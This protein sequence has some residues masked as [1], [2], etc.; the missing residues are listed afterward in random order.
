M[1]GVVL[2][3]GQS[4]RMGRDKALVDVDGVAM[5][6]RVAE[7]QR[8]AGCADVVL[9]G[10]S[11]RAVDGLGLEVLRE[12][13]PGLGPLSGIDAG[14]NAA[15][16]RGHDLMMCCPCDV[17]DVTSA[18]LTPLV[19]AM[20]DPSID[21]ACVVSDRGLEPLVSLWRAQSCCPVVRESLLNSDLAVRRV[22]GSLNM[23][24]VSVTSPDAVANMNTQSDL[25]RRAK[26]AFTDVADPDR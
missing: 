3:G 10:A 21:V 26:R 23:V 18:Q 19:E 17:P 22:L 15:L 5:A 8:S 12:A 24:T 2:A 14:L 16:D 4:R 11:A 25:N 20:S 9:G 6:I 13:H 7:A 1:L